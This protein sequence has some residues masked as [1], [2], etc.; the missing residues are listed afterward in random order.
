MSSP[1]EPLLCQTTAKSP[2]GA[3]ATADSS[4]L[5]GDPRRRCG[6]TRVAVFDREM[7]AGRLRSQRPALVVLE[8]DCLISDCENAFL[9]WGDEGHA[10]RYPVCSHQGRPAAVVR[11]QV[12]HLQPA[13][14]TEASSHMNNQRGHSAGVNSRTPA[15]KTTIGAQPRRGDILRVATDPIFIRVASLRCVRSRRPEAELDGER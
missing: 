4:W 8:I 13:K 7:Q 1:D 6:R 12:N 5:L 10:S 15:G 3:T 2:A 14:T 11:R 9:S